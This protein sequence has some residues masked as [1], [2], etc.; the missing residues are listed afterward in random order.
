MIWILFK[1]IPFYFFKTNLK[2]EYK[3]HRERN[4]KVSLEYWVLF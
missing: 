1:K 4:E 2:Y 3:K